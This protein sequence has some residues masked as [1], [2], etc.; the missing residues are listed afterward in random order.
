M[1]MRTDP[2]CTLAFRL[3]FKPHS[4]IITSERERERKKIEKFLK[5]TNIVKTVTARARGFFWLIEASKHTNTCV[6][7]LIDSNKST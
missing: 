4:T 6:K 1:Y 2:A 3:N 5:K 7:E